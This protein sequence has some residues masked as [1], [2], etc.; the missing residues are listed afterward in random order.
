MMAVATSC[1]LESEVA[2]DMK[3][4]IFSTYVAVEMLGIWAVDND[5]HISHIKY[6]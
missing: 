6:L 2:R 5:G 3:P 4:G 1:I